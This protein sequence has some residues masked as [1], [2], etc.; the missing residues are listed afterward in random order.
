MSKSEAKGAV[1]EYSAQPMCLCLEKIE[2]QFRRDILSTLKYAITQSISDKSVRADLHAFV[3]FN[4]RHFREQR[5]AARLRWIELLWFLGALGRL[6]GGTRKCERKYAGRK[7]NDM[8]RRNRKR[9][10][11]TACKIRAQTIHAELLPN[12]IAVSKTREKRVVRSRGARKAESV[13][14]AIIA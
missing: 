4:E 14:S 5:D 2:N 8:L 12:A 7:I 9:S 13:T 3:E 1:N 10:N 11:G 6:G